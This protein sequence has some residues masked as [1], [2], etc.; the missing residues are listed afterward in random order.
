MTL[1]SPRHLHGTLLLFRVNL[2]RE[3]V[4][5]LVWILGLLALVLVSALSVRGLFPDQAAL[6]AAA[7]SSRNPAVQ[8]F[9]GPPLGLNS[10]GGQIV[11]QIGAPGLAVMA[12]MAIMMTGRLTRDEEQ[13]GRTELIRSLPVGTLAPGAAALAL[14]GGMSLVIGCGN[15]VILA[16][17]VPV[18]GSIAF[19]LGYTAMGLLFAAIVMVTAQLTTSGRAAKGLAGA[20]L[21]TMFLIRAFGDAAGS[22]LSW[23][24]PMGWVQAVRPFADE[25]WWPFLLLAL[26]T[27]G[28]LYG[29][30][31]LYLGRDIGSAAVRF[32]S[33]LRAW[34]PNSGVVKRS[35]A[36][37]D[38]VVITTPLGLAFR[39]GFPLFMAWAAGLAAASLA[40]GSLSSA[41]NDFI[42]DNPQ[43]ADLIDLG[44]GSGPVG[45]RLTGAFVGAAAKIV[46]TMAGAFAVQSALALRREESSGRA[47]AFAALPV[48][49]RR[50]W[51]SMAIPTAAG[52]VLVLAAAGLMLGVGAALSTGDAGMVETG[53][54]AMVAYTPAMWLFAAVAGLLTGWKPTWTPA[55]WGIYGLAAAISMFGPMLQ[56]PDWAMA[57]SGF[58]LVPT[59]PTEAFDVIPWLGLVAAAVGV[60]LLGRVG[61]ERRDLAS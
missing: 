50:Y 12:L 45:A 57:V 52:S 16:T 20:L 48:S 40:Y 58:D 54:V 32:G 47:E 39:V 49:R 29:A 22:W 10:L 19:G 60:F 23:L 34:A 28:A 59:L 55:A 13:D 42:D 30:Q 46:A 18:G 35:G 2:R 38:Q 36:S 31:V 1:A 33:P 3:R 5:V 56:F 7:T 51:G 14:V 9:N 26:V 44:S 11:F 4:R 8:A 43:L 6:D 17:M 27:L 37:R 41:M 61:Y 53:L 15:A 24:S 25:R 21:G